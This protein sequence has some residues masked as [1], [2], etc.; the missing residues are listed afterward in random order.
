[1][2]ATG[3]S[4]ALWTLLAFPPLQKRY[5]TGGVLRACTIVWPIFFCM[6]PLS[7]FLLRQNLIVLFWTFGPVATVIGTGIAIA[8][9]KSYTCLN[10]PQCQ[11]SN[12]TLSSG[13]AIGSERHRAFA[14]H[15]GNSEWAC[16]LCCRCF[17]IYK[18]GTVY[19]YLCH[20]SQ[21]PNLPRLSCLD[22]VDCHSINLDIYYE[23]STGKSRGQDLFRTC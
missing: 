15:F 3:L 2:G 10:S 16:S 17:E 18:P 23:R 13:D 11:S 9:S 21:I 19:Q 8:F 6:S 20:W 22:R 12:L 1:M 5:G 7:N 4:Q 14:I